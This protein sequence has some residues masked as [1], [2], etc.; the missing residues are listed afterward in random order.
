MCSKGGY[1]DTVVGD[2]DHVVIGTQAKVVLV[3]DMGQ[4][5]GVFTH[6]H[7]RYVRFHSNE[8]LT[9]RT[10]EYVDFLSSFLSKQK[11]VLWT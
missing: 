10:D 6:R 8:A 11:T 5:V 4:T 9:T 3:M 7:E 1:T 2:L